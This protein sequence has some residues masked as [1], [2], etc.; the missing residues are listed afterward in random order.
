[1]KLRRDKLA[2]V[3]PLGLPGRSQTV[4]LS[5]PPDEHIPA[6]VVESEGDSLLVALL[7][8]RAP[9]TRRELDGLVL[10]FN[11]QRGRVRLRA[12]VTQE[13]P[14]EAEL[15][16]LEGVRAIDVL[17]ER[18]YVRVSSARPVLVY[19]GA[20]QLQVQSYTV[21]VSGGGL[22]L[23]GPESLRIGE[24]IKFHLSL[25]S[26]EAPITGVGRVVRTDA[27]GRRAVN[28]DE[29][30]DFDRRRLVRFI[31]DCQRVE[32]QRGLQQDV[33]DGP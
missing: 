23:A 30:S 31:F 22:L 17:Q 5:I 28:F 10:E 26:G 12:T 14:A 4:T 16:R 19:C 33:T 2:K 7:I 20:D 11:D 29:I 13:D 18:E 1:M 32:R 24:E 6:R 15:V 9:L 25:A 8:T 21:D 27:K 3:E